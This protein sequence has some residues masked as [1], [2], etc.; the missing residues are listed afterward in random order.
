M[1]VPGAKNIVGPAVVRTEGFPHHEGQDVGQVLDSCSCPDPPDG[2]HVAWRGSASGMGILLTGTRRFART[3][4]AG[5]RL[6]SRQRSSDIDF[7]RG[8]GASL[9]ASRQTV[10]DWESDGH[11]VATFRDVAPDRRPRNAARRLGLQQRIERIRGVGPLAGPVDGGHE[12]GQ[13]SERTASGLPFQ[14][15]LH[16]AP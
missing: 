15:L 14:S 3:S 9:R 2:D 6:A 5:G 11:P 16:D 10:F 7:W 1:F 4:S 13:L 12:R 8:E